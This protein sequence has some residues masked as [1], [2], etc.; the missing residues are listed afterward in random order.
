MSAITDVNNF[1]ADKATNFEEIEQ[2]WSVK[3]VE[4]LAAY[5]NLITSIPPSKI[6]LTNMDDEIHDQFLEEFPE[7]KDH[8]LLAHLDED[9]MKSPE[10]KVRWRK[11]ISQYEKTV[12]DYNFGTM[13]RKD[14]DRLYAEDNAILVTRVQFLAIE[15]SRNRAG[16]NNK[17]YEQ[18]QKEKKAEQA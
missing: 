6:K 14:S 17:V 7:Y 10:G 4:H 16:L 15:I 3:T 11:F 1:T 12:T 5:E 13:V 8:Q 2:Q 18:A 9:K